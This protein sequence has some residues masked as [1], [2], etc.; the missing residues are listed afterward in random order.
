MVFFMYMHGFKACG[1]SMFVLMQVDFSNCEHIVDV[2]AE[3]F[4]VKLPSLSCHH[5]ETLWLPQI[6]VFVMSG[7][8]EGVS[9][10][11]QHHVRN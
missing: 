1:S 9:C 2:R 6:V 3:W 4:D 7:L 10:Q 5:L 11:L 8:R